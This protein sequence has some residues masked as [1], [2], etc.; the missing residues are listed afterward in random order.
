MRH[1]EKK[2]TILKT[3]QFVKPELYPEI[4]WLVLKLR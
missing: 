3:N 4:I 2:L 1:M